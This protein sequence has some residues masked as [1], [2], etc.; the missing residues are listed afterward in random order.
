MGAKAL[1]HVA[2]CICAKA[3]PVFERVKQHFQKNN[4]KDSA[5]PKDATAMQGS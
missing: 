2:K 1:A 5:S 4:R 3:A